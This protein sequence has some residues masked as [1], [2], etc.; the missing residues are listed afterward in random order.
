MDRTRIALAVYID[1]DSVPGPGYSADSM[2]HIVSNVIEE[3]FGQYNPRVSIRS[4]DTSRPIFTTT[5]TAAPTVFAFTGTRDGMTEIQK[6]VVRDIL[7]ENATFLH[8]GAARGADAE[9][10]E[11]ANKLGIDVIAHPASGVKA[12]DKAAIEAIAY[13]PELP[14]LQRNRKMVDKS[15]AILATPVGFIEQPRGSGTWSTIRYAKD[16]EKPLYIVFPDGTIRKENF[17]A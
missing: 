11:I 6:E 2:R 9:A 13:R 15:Q 8:N 17:A 16:S 3:N 12:E 4:Y 10:A 7:S 14:P 1:L 5:R